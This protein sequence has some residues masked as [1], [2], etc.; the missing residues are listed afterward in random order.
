MNKHGMLNQ[1]QLLFF[2]VLMG[3]D[4][5]NGIK[6]LGKNKAFKLA[7]LRSPNFSTRFYQIVA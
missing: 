4:Y 3:N 1:R 6:G 2:S 5:S 7:T